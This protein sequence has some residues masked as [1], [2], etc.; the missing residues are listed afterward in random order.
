MSLHFHSSLSCE[1]AFSQTKIKSKS[2]HLISLHLII[3]ILIIQYCPRNRYGQNIEHEWFFPLPHMMTPIIFCKESRTYIT[4]RIRALFLHFSEIQPLSQG[5]SLYLGGTRKRPAEH[6]R[7]DQLS[8]S[9][10]SKGIKYIHGHYCKLLC[11][12]GRIQMPQ[13]QEQRRKHL[14]HHHLSSQEFRNTQRLM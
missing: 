9:L 7:W 10:D 14:K 2:L 8:T 12:T 4:N 1:D 11:D 3:Q 5:S 13:F 6:V